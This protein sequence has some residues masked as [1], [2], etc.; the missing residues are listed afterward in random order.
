MNDLSWMLY[1]ADVLPSLAGGVVFISF[2]GGVI[3]L[4]CGI[5]AVSSA[6]DDE[7]DVCRVLKHGFWLFPLFIVFALSANFVPSK[8]TFYAIAASEAGE[9]LLKTSEVGKARAA[10]NKW[11][12]KQLTDGGTPK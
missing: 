8:D 9:E 12:D 2:L 10:L 6:Y 3:S 5:I 11:L 4:V 7:P 1:W